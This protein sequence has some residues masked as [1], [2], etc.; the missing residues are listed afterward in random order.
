MKRLLV[1]LLGSLTAAALCLPPAALAEP[2][3]QRLA[4]TTHF[5][6][7]RSGSAVV[8]LH[9]PVE[10][11][12]FPFN[13]KLAKIR[14]TGRVAGLVLKQ[15]VPKNGVEVLAISLALCPK[16]PCK[17]KRLDV[18]QVW[19]PAERGF[20]KKVT[21]PAGNYLVYLIAEDKT[22]IELRLPGLRG[23]A[24]ASLS[25]SKAVDIVEPQATFDPL[26]QHNV[27]SAEAKQKLEGIG[28]AMLAVEIEA[29]S[30][31]FSEIDTCL[32]KR[33]R[34]PVIDDVSVP[35]LF[36]TCDGSGSS[37]TY[38]AGRPD[39]RRQVILN[40]DTV[41]KGKYFHGLSYK[42]VSD[43]KEANALAVDISLPRGKRTSGFGSATWWDE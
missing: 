40:L 31:V 2:E 21:L 16:L 20:P 19:D 4:G 6:G 28:W 25:S 34:R 11:S 8:R 13:N 27:Y 33:Q 3:A 41:G 24:T 39:S 26:P 23:Q 7:T 30:E 32:Q 42:T 10:I 17:E 22:E 38:I 14:S 43:L 35:F 9:R 1:G 37:T 5:T 12:S 15:D 29:D 18:T 36:E